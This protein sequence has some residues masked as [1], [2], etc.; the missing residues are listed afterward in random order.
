MFEMRNFTRKHGASDRLF[1][2]ENVLNT[3]EIQFLKS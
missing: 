3:I 2:V 1:K